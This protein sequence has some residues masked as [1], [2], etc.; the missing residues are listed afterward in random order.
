VP[1][2][3]LDLSSVLRDASLSH[4]GNGIYGE[5]WV[6]AL[7]ACAFVTNDAGAAIE[8]ALGQVPARS[9]FA[10]VVRKVVG[11][12]PSPVDEL[13]ERTAVLA[14]GEPRR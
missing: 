12:G 11:P 9:R 4:T 10:E 13:A 5:L 6:A 7:L 8:A 1:H 2:D 14:L 3:P